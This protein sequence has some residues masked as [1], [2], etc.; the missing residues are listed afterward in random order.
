MTDK[1]RR[2]LVEAMIP[3]EVLA[4]QIRTKPYKEMS[5]DFQA[6]LLKSIGVIRDFVL[7]STLQGNSNENT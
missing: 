5:V 7:P 6:K 1:Q 4:G 3:L 2:E